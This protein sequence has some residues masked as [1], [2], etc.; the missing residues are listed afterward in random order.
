[1]YIQYFKSRKFANGHLYI[2]GQPP[3]HVH[4]HGHTSIGALSCG[5]NANS[6][7]DKQKFGFILKTVRIY[8]FQLSVGYNNYASL[9]ML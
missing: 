6:H 8:V 9:I 2:A 4:G 5:G 3:T 7:F 1:M